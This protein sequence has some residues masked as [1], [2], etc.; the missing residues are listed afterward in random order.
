MSFKK[1]FIQYLL[2]TIYLV[3]VHAPE[4]MALPQSIPDEING[5]DF[6]SPG[7]PFQF[8]ENKGQLH[9]QNNEKRDEILFSGKA[10]AA[11]FY[12]PD[13]VLCQLTEVEIWKNIDD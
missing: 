9:D 11:H 6:K 8:I 2:T 3:N 5:P 4:I 10:G 12:S 13:E 7:F 1:S